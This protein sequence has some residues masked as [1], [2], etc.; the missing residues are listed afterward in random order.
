MYFFCYFSG[1]ED[2]GDLGVSVFIFELIQNIANT[3]AIPAR[4]KPIIFDD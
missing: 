3:A 4:P 2:E 1:D